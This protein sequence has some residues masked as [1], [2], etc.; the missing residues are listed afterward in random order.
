[1]DNYS[2]VYA[3]IC[4]V[5]NSYSV[6][7]T[8]EILVYRTAT[9]MHI[10]TVKWIKYSGVYTCMS[11]VFN[12]LLYSFTPTCTCTQILMFKNVHVH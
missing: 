3:C 9:H 4:K 8:A 10:F 7:T 11:N 5:L 2:D 1:M 6:R 12:V